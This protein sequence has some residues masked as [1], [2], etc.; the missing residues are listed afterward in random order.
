MD[1]ISVFAS[2]FGVAAVWWLCTDRLK[3]AGIRRVSGP[4]HWLCWHD[5]WQERWKSCDI[6]YEW[7]WDG[8]RWSW[9]WVRALEHCSPNHPSRGALIV[10]WQDDDEQ[11]AA[12]ICIDEN[13]CRQTW[14]DG[15][16]PSDHI[17]LWQEREERKRWWRAQAWT[18]QTMSKVEGLSDRDVHHIMALV[19]GVPMP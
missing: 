6:H 12:W 3:P 13:G 7:M 15:L 18:R 14:R 11:A 9:E 2:A 4:V 10:F 17:K 1:A 8:L 16:Y 5:G 19:T